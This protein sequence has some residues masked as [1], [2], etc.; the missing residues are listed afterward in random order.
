MCLDRYRV[1]AL[2][3]LV[4]RARSNIYFMPKYFADIIEKFSHRQRVFVLVVLLVFSSGTYLLGTYLKQDDCSDLRRENI[5]LHRDFIAISQMI[6]QERARKQEQVTYAEVAEEAVEA[7][8]ETIVYDTIWTIEPEGA[9]ESAAEIDTTFTIIDISD[10][11]LE[12]ILRISESHGTGLMF[13]G[14]R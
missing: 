12:D 14:P 5:D 7:T 11:M 9:T 8:E 6:R 4:T 13:N 1:I 2:K 10:E 3:T